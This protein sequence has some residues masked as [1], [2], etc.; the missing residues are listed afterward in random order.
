VNGL[1]RAVLAPLRG[2]FARSVAILTSAA[3][4]QN[5]LVLATSP[6]LSRLFS[7]EEFGVAGLVYAFAAVPTVAATGHYFLAIMQTRKRVESVN[8][9]VLSWLIVFSVSFLASIIV[10]VIYYCRNI[11]GGFGD[12][13]GGNIFFIPILML[14]EASRTVGRIWEVRHADYRSL[15]RNRLIE[16]VGTIISQISAG[17]A[18]VGAIGLVGGRLLGIAASAFDLFYTFARDIGR[19]GRRSVRLGK[20][21]Q[22]ARR[23]WR[24]PVYQTPADLLGCL[25]RQIP[26]I[27][28][29]AYF[30]VG[31]VGLY[32]LANRILERPTQLF[33]ADMNRVFVQRVADERGRARDP[34]RL[35]I[36]SA[37]AMAALSLPPFLLIIAFGPDL[38]SVFFGREWRQA[39]EY[40]RWMALF[41]FGSLCALPAR[42]MTTVYGLQRVYVIVETVRALLGAVFIVA[43]AE[44]TNNDVTAVAAFSVVQLAVIAVF[45]AVIPVLVRNRHV[46]GDRISAAAK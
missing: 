29:A 24:F 10:T 27:F 6:I 25:C 9:I 14:L 20:L 45:V 41:S 13:L 31:A 8:I 38:F 1:L 37:L 3:L 23:H 35:F 7:P 26:P 32:W 33:G 12:Q 16:T 5:A 28:L 2:T 36:K 40:G 15:F 44:L 34:A 18:G 21:K 11:I 39:G 43:A 42:S 46:A 22:V 17:L 4:L 19:S 30:S